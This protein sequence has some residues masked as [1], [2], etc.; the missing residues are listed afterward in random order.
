MRDI[1]NGVLNEL[2]E[3]RRRIFCAVKFDGLT[4]VEAAIHLGVSPR[5]VVKR[6]VSAVLNGL[7]SALKDYL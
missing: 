6:E 3:L 7:R 5:K 2:P 4:Y 1:F